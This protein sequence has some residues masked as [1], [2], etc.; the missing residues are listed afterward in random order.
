MT[1]PATLSTT[2]HSDRVLAYSTDLG[3]NMLVLGL[4]LTLPFLALAGAFLRAVVLFLPTMWILNWTHAVIPM[5]PA[6]EWWPTFLVIMLLGLLIPHAS[7][8]TTSKK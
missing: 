6:L 4:L 2:E 7:V 1:F 5:V 8:N 3:D